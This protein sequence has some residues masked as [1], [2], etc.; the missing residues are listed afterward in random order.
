MKKVL[1]FLA[2]LFVAGSV[3][4]QGNYGWPERHNRNEITVEN[5]G[6]NQSITIDKNV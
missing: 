1:F 4:A 5:D 2:F 6:Q 3:F